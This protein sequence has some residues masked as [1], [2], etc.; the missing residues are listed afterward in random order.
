MR[1]STINKGFEP[2]TKVKVNNTQ[3]KQRYSLW[4]SMAQ[5]H[6]LAEI[7]RMREIKTA[8]LVTEIITKYIDREI[9]QG[10]VNF[11]APQHDVLIPILK[12][13]IY[14]ELSDDEKLSHD[15]LEAAAKILKCDVTRIY[16][17]LS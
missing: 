11:F 8:T 16:D 13:L 15:K 9:L 12:A 5:H 6:Y 14:G 4:L 17:L 10:T 1:K 7:A 2:V 3:T